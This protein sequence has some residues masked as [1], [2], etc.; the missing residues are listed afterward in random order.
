LEKKKWCEISPVECDKKCLK[1]RVCSRKG[2][3][4]KNEKHK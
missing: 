3:T 4:V 1:T 2:V